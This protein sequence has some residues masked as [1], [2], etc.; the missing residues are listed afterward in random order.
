MST[1]TRRLAKRIA[2]AAPAAKRVGARPIPADGAA[3]KRR[4]DAARAKADG[5]AANDAAPRY[6]QIA[7]ELT[8][9]ISSGRYPVGARLPTELELCERFGISRFTAREA[10]RV[11]S[12]AGLVTR[13]QRVGTVVIATPAD[14]RYTHAASSV[15][16]LFQYAQDTELRLMYIGKVA[17]AADRA[18]QFGAQVGDEWIYA[19]G[20]RRESALADRDEAG[21]PI[22]ITRLYLSPLLKGI[23]AKL[24]ERK[25]AVYAIIE[26][27][28]GLVIQRVEQEL[29]SV[30][31]DADDAANLGAAPGSPA[32]LV[33][34]RY[35]DESGQLLE[36]AENIHPG[37]R[38]TYKMQLNK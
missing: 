6:L 21:R 5:D 34:R 25:T 20:M 36:V 24:R 3:S 12:T 16:D 19:M 31:L 35:F 9:A 30:A 17:L 27:E 14:A 10:V 28:Y 11:L 1:A 29:Q 37:D 18:A 32:L 33:L 8:A 2:G 4:R 38:F 26:R 7:R 22:C 23:E 15:A 13:R